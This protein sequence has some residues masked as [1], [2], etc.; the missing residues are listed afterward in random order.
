MKILVVDDMASMRNV[1][2]HMLKSLGH[3]NNDEAENGLQALKMLRQSHYDLLVTDLHMPNLNGKQLLEK[4]RAD[5]KLHD[6]PVLMVTSEDDRSVVMSLIAEKVTGFIV[7]P[8]KLETLKKQL[9]KIN[10]QKVATVNA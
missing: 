5:Q 8:F 6:L 9:S 2:V 7:K 10:Y 3:H 4:V 1:M